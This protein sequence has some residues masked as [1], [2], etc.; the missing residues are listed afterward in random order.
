MSCYVQSG[1][2]SSAVIEGNG[3]MGK[4]GKECL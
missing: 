2:V 3:S 4:S 1:R